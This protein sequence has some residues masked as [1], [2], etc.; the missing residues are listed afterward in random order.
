MTRVF[1]LKELPQGQE[2]GETIDVT[3]GEALALIHVGAARLAVFDDMPD[4]DPAAPSP[5][6]RR[7]YHRRD[8]QAEP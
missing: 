6:R 4:S 3:D 8:L 2:P 7:A 1:V 5:R